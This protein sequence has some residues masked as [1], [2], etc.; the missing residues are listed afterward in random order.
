MVDVMLRGC[1]I[2]QRIVLLILVNQQV[3]FI[4]GDEQPDTIQQ[5]FDYQDLTPAY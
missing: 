3:V 4:L 5:K 2:P 1:S